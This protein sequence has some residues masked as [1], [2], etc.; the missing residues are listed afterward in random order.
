M[1]GWCCCDRWEQWR[2]WN[3]E[4]HA[5][6]AASLRDQILRLRGRASLLLWLNGSDNPPPPRVE[7]MYLAILRELEWVSPVLSSA[8]ERATEVSGP[9]GVKMRGPYDY[10]PPEYWRW[11]TSRG[12]AFGFA[13]EITPG[14]AIPPV[15]S[16][17]SML[18]VEHLWPIDSSWTYHAGGGVF[19]NLGTFTAAL[20]ERYGKAGSVADYARK[21]QAAAYESHRA[22]F[23]AYR[24]NKYRSTGVIQWM[25]N[26][27]WPSLIWHLYDFYL[28]PGGSYFGVKKAC[29]PLHVQV[30][31][32]DRWVWVVSSLP[33]PVSDLVVTAR[34]FDLASVE[35]FH[36]SRVVSVSPDSSS[37]VL[38][39]PELAGLG[40][41]SFVSVV[42][43]TSG[44]RGVSTN[45]YWLSS[46]P[47][48]LDGA[49]A[50]WYLTPIASYADLTAL[51]GLPA[52]SVKVSARH[53]ADGD[54]GRV[55]VTLRN[56]SSTIALL[57]HVSVLRREDGAEVLPILWEDNYV[58]LLPGETREIGARFRTKDAGRGRV[59]VRLE[60]WNVASRT[61]EAVRRHPG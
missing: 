21:A 56:G 11:D 48:V 45:F 10:E 28:R 33:G 39:I 57:L 13:T 60:G 25:L 54:A 43:A 47:D 31:V 27:A 32:D 52:A 19:A 1:A 15:E 30:S 38:E 24:Q 50:Q 41:A 17:R 26:N 53:V 4:D 46:K 3:D 29:D 8:S 42:L 5:V 23:E 44:G 51:S 35:R 14:P 55:T 20:E 2:E 12:G 49:K 34:V 7:R 16:L 61:V 58:S 59:R 9:T 22:M 40:P 37:K 6:A 36:A 18:P